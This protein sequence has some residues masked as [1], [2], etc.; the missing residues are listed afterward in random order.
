MPTTISLPVHELAPYANRALA[1]ARR[2]GSAATVADLHRVTDALLASDGDARVIHPQTLRK[3]LNERDDVY[4]REAAPEEKPPRVYAN[5]RLYLYSLEEPVPPYSLELHDQLAL[6]YPDPR[7]VPVAR[8][9]RR[10]PSE[11][12][13]QERVNGA[14]NERAELLISL[15][16][17]LVADVDTK[18]E[19][20]T[21]E[22]ESEL[23]SARAEIERLSTLVT[24]QKQQL[25]AVARA[26]KLLDFTVE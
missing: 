26:Q 23:E 22:L 14:T 18:Q 3:W 16:R 6:E 20:A 19:S 21:A 8:D 2:R 15:V 13:K 4:R 17:E 24:K 7:L 10:K 11:R 25:R 9:R 12:T 1:L 5:V